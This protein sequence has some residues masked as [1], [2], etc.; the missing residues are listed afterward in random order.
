MSLREQL[1]LKDG[2]ARPPAILRKV[3]VHNGTIEL[4]SRARGDMVFDID[5]F[6]GRQEE[7]YTCLQCGHTISVAVMM[8]LYQ[9][10]ILYG[11]PIVTGRNIKLE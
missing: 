8:I 9:H 10:Y 4:P 7:T 5:F 11:T 1:Q 3:C 2:K 6:I